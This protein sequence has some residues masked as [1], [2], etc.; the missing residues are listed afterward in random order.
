MERKYEP[1]LVLKRKRK[2]EG[3]SGEKLSV[4]LGL[5]KPI[6]STYEIG[7]SRA[8]LSVRN[9]LSERYGGTE[10]DYRQKPLKAR[11]VRSDA[12][13]P[14][15]VNNR[16]RRRIYGA[17][18]TVAEV[19]D[20][21][22]MCR[23]A[24]NNYLS[25]K[26][27][28]SECVAGWVAPI[29]GCSVEDLITPAWERYLVENPGV[30]NKRLGVG[31]NCAGFSFNAWKRA[32]HLEGVRDVVG[33]AMEKLSERDREILIEC[34]FNENSLVSLAGGDRGCVAKLFGRKKRALMRLGDIL[35]WMGF[36]KLPAHGAEV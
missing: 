1:N 34:Y 35:D 27:F 25:G 5:S 7:C 22:G 32:C 10:R 2:A 14:D 29:V 19:C 6:V 24:L 30:E 15:K 26:K 12:K 17:G 13:N 8:S 18:L 11:A 3:I 31:Y 36:K 16:L 33:K 9:A 21:G 20:I 23:A 4:K 28:V